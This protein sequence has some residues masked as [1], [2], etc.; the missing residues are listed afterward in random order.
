MRACLRIATAAQAALGRSPLTDGALATARRNGFPLAV[1]AHAPVLM[2]RGGL[3][4]ACCAVATA[5]LAGTGYLTVV[6]T[7]SD[8][9]QQINFPDE[10]GTLLT[11]TS[12]VSSLQQVDQLV[13][14]SI[15]PGFGGAVLQN[16]LVTGQTALRDSV[17]LGTDLR[18]HTI[19]FGGPSSPQNPFAS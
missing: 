16:L 10:T 15:G 7:D 4:D 9:N 8:Q 5:A 3:T 14:G 1:G 19:G 18:R 13:R 6:F 2:A 17:V 11:T 12:N